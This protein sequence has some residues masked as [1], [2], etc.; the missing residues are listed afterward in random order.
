[1]ADLVLPA[2]EMDCRDW[3][4]VSASEA[5]LPE[6]VEGAPLL[7]VLSTMVIDDDV[8]EATGALTVG[9]IDDDE[10][11]VRQVA[12]GSVAHELVDDDPAPGKRRYIMP[13][14]NRQLALLAEFVVADD[15]VEH[16]AEPARTAD[17]VV[18]SELDRRV[19]ALMTSF[20]W[21]QAD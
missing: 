19:E 10:L 4:V 16:A 20:R 11:A 7:A 8:R 1:M 21:Q 15:S 18:T 5:G 14:P 3:I 13:A 12:P 2:F 17:P 9:I 6:D